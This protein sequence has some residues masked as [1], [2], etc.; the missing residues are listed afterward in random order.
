MNNDF[1]APDHVVRN[2]IVTFCTIKFSL[3]LRLDGVKG[4]AEDSWLQFSK[5]I[6]FAPLQSLN[7]IVKL[8]FPIDS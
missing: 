1:L 2:N 7:L 5:S 4:V 3:K 8:L 6:P